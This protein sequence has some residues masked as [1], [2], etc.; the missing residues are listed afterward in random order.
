[1]HELDE[2]RLRRSCDRAADGYAEADFFC[3]EV[4]GRLLERLTLITLQPATVVDLGGGTGESMDLLRALYPGAELINLDWSLAMLRRAAGRADSRSVCAD[5]HRLPFA[6]ASVDI[7]VSNMM[8]PGCADPVAVF[9]EARRVLRTPGLLLFST[10]GPDTLKE[11]R[12][13]WPADDPHPHVHAFADMHNIGD[14]LVGAGFREPVMDVEM[15]TVNYRE[16]RRL[17]TDL[18]AVAATNQLA[19]RRRSLTGTGRWRSFAANLEAG[20]D[21]EGRFAVSIEAVT[22]QAW[23]GA[24]DRGVPLQDGE[25]RFPLS[26]LKF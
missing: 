11:V 6:D 8:V 1:M 19:A 24:P 13:A 17:V 3:R 18:R 23:T 20:R 22:G 14:A 9:R 21:A 25:A 15:L 5:S 4:R 26:R 10:L 2:S 7:I 16:V 12:R